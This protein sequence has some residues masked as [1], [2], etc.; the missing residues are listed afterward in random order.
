MVVKINHKFLAVFI[1]GYFLLNLVCAQEGS[2]KLSSEKAVYSLGE[3]ILIYA[4]VENTGESIALINLE[5]SLENEMGSYPVSVIP[6]EFVL[7]PNENKKVLLYNI[8]VDEDMDPDLYIVNVN[9]LLNY[10]RITKKFLSFQIINTLE[11]FDFDIRVC[12]DSSCKEESNI[13]VKNEEVYLDSVSDIEDLEL[14]ASLIHPD[15][16]KENINLPKTIEASQIGT[17][18]LEVSASKEGYKTITKKEQ[19]GVI[20]KEAEI[21]TAGPQKISEI[22]SKEKISE[23]VKEKGMWLLTILVIAIIAVVIIII[24]IKRK[25]LFIRKKGIKLAKL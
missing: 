12:K 3:T 8:L 24:Y 21:K 2:L 9:L 7:R 1:I 18:E 16:E 6:F 13:F 14:K 19:F 11:D 5:S 10:K 22:I 15:G 25:R 4:E 20:E 23:I 17:Y